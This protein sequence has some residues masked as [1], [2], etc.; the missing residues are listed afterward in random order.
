MTRKRERNKIYFLSRYE[1]SSE[2]RVRENLVQICLQKEMKL[3][4]TKTVRIVSKV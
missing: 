4:P 2:T 1:I 3:S